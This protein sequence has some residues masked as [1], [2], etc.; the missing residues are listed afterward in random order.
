MILEHTINH[1][2]TQQLNFENVVALFQTHIY[3]TVGDQCILSG[4]WT[5]EFLSEMYERSRRV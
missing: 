4:T 5:P 3:T 1:G 2:V